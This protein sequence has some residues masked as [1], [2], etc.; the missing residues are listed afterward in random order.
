MTQSQKGTEHE[1][2]ARHEERANRWSKTPDDWRIPELEDDWPLLQADLEAAQSTPF[3][4]KRRES[5]KPYHAGFSF[6]EAMCLARTGGTTP[7]AR[8]IR[9]PEGRKHIGEREW[10]HLAAFVHSLWRQPKRP[11]GRPMSL[12][13]WTL[14][15][16]QS[17]EGDSYAA[18]MFLVRKII[19]AERAAAELV[20]RRK[21][22]WRGTHNRTRVPKAESDRMIREAIE[23]VA[24]Q[25]N[26][27]KDKVLADNVWNALKTGRYSAQ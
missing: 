19:D 7:L 14:T 9:D 17:Q 2:S 1:H 12:G 4:P 8:F 23:E 21:A 5:T 13:I 6:Q 26:V 22:A 15:S 3:T 20:A 18:Q 16:D 11:R 24:A 10:K 27:P 25:R